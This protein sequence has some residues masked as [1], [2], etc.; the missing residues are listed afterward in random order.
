MIMVPA[1]SE[2]EKKQKPIALKSAVPLKSSQRGVKRN[3]TPAHPP[4]SVTPRMMRITI[5]MNR[6]GIRILAIFSMPCC[7]PFMTT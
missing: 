5:R 6:S 4:G 2:S 3:S 1:P 7:T